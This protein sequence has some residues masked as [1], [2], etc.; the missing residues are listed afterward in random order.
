MIVSKTTERAICQV[1]DSGPGI[2]AE[3]IPFIFERFYRADPARKHSQEGSGLGLS[4][5]RGL[6]EA[7]HGG[8]E[9][10]S[11]A[12]RGTIMTFWLPVYKI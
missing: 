10:S 7:H 11:V 12:G 4:I 3:H 1:M 8:V 6:V 5:V 2:P 9:V